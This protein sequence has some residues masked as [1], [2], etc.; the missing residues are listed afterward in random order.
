[1]CT[2]AHSS[3]HLPTSAT[4]AP[5]ASRWRTAPTKVHWRI[6]SALCDR[7]RSFWTSLCEPMGE[8]D[9]QIGRPAERKRLLQRAR[10]PLVSGK[11][12]VGILLLCLGVT[13]L[14]VLP[15]ARRFSAW[16]DVEIVLGLWWTVWTITLVYL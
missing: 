3:P 5:F 12:S 7:A 11:A 4:R 2:G 16:V 15:L 9:S 1:M 10:L 8:T 6:G 13:A 14:W